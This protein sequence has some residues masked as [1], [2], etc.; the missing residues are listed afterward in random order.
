MT[1]EIEL[2]LEQLVAQFGEKQVL[3]SA[4]PARREMQMERLAMRRQ[5]YPAYS[6]PQRAAHHSLK[7]PACWCVSITLPAESKR[8]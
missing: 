8:A 4:G 6:A 1:R 3:G 5:Y 2:Q 7:S